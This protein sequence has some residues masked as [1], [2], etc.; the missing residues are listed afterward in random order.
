MAFNVSRSID[1]KQLCNM[2]IFYTHVTHYV[3][4]I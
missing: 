2:I 1:I 4:E 3:I